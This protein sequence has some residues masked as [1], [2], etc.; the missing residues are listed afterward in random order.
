MLLDARATQQLKWNSAAILNNEYFLPFLFNREKLYIY[1]QNIAHLLVDQFSSWWEGFGQGNIIDN[2]TEYL[3]IHCDTNTLSALEM[4]YWTQFIILR[5]VFHWL[6]TELC[7]HVS[8]LCCFLCFWSKHVTY[9]NAL[10]LHSL[11][12][13]SQIKYISYWCVCCICI[14][15]QVLSHGDVSICRKQLV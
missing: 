9:S 7:L 8:L 3:Q 6:S 14:Q 11:V 1:K 2:N 10:G 12:S 4:I 13:F 5:Y 15:S